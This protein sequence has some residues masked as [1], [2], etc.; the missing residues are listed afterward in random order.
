[1][2][3]LKFINIIGW[4]INVLRY[5]SFNGI[6]SRKEFFKVIEQERERANRNNHQVSLVV[7]NLDSF[8]DNGKER[9]QLINNIL[10]KKRKIDETGWYR[11]H[12]VGVIL[13]YT[14]S[15][16]ARKFSVRLSRTLNFIMPDSFCHVFTY[17]FESKSDDVAENADDSAAENIVADDVEN[18]S[19][20]NDKNASARSV[21]S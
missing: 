16:G 18:K 9:K 2:R 12:S 7:F 5:K 1:M 14:S 11:K 15:H 13:P 6:N 4:P 8:P 19:D 21:S 3:K 10:K 20:D 17:P